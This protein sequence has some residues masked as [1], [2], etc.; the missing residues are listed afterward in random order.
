MFPIFFRPSSA[1]FPP[2]LASFPIRVYDF[3]LI[4]LRILGLYFYYLRE[5]CVGLVYYTVFHLNSLFRYLRHPHCF[6]IH[7]TAVKTRVTN[8]M[9]SHLEIDPI[10]RNKIVH[11]FHRCKDLW[12]YYCFLLLHQEPLAVICNFYFG[13]VLLFEP[14]NFWQNRSYGLNKTTQVVS[15]CFHTFKLIKRNLHTN[16]Q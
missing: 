6:R 1:S 7:S 14:R 13:C 12:F 8:E 11:L 10:K 5:N 9:V 15:F 16:F 3:C 4:L 2:F